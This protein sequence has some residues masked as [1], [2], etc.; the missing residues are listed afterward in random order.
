MT[1]F[2]KRKP[3]VVAAVVKKPEISIARVAHMKARAEIKREDADT[4]GELRRTR[5]TFENN[6]LI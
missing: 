2:F 3:V 1:F 4:T 5:Q 6:R